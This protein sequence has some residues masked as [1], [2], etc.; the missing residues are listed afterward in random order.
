MG[1]IMKDSFLL[2]KKLK[3]FFFSPWI[4]KVMLI[5]ALILT[6]IVRFSILFIPF[7]KLARR[8]GKYKEESTKQLSDREK[9]IVYN[10][11]WSVVAIA[12]RTP[13]ESKCLVKALTAQIMLKQRKISSTLYLG[14]SKDNE[15]KLKAHA[16]L[17]CGED[18]I[19]GDNEREGFTVVAKFAN[20]A[21]VGGR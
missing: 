3:K 19:T 6:G 10:V 7:S 21:K 20:N 15:K 8:I 11:A 16:W 12:K 1:Y 5:E 18:I 14:V 2:F 4:Q 9:Y 17:R 13:W